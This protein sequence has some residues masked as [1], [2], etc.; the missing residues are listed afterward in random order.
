MGGHSVE[1]HRVVDQPD[2]ESAEGGGNLDKSRQGYTPVGT[3]VRSPQEAA[4]PI[5]KAR[6]GRRNTACRCLD[7][8]PATSREGGVALLWLQ[9]EEREEAPTATLL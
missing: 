8:P 9:R 7:R 6:W 2:D 3:L 4:D 1:Y 5:A